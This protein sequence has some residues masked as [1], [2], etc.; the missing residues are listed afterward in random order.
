VQILL[1]PFRR[2]VSPPSSG[3]KNPRARNQHEQVAADTLVPRSRIVLPWR[4]RRYV[5]EMSVQ[6]RST[7]RHIPEDGI[8]HSHRCENLKSYT[9]TLLIRR[10]GI[11]PCYKITAETS[12][13]SEVHLFTN[14]NKSKLHTWGLLCLPVC[15]ANATI[16]KIQVYTT[17]ILPV[18][19]TCVYL[20]L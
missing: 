16:I 15:H 4:W 18:I 1:E 9:S 2:N 5:H 19:C 7:Q 3:Q 13:I 11:K 17:I 8:L 6:T 20:L 14:D 10:N 12:Q